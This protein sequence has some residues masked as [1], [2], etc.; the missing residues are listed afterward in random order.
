MKK[1][2]LV[3][4]LV[5]ITVSGVFAQQ[6]AGR[7]GV[8]VMGQYNLGFG[9]ASGSAGASLSLKLPQSPIFWGLRF[10][11]SGGFAF[12]LTGDVYFFSQNLVSGVDFGYRVAVGAY[13]RLAAGNNITDVGLGLRLPLGVYFMPIDFLELFFNVVPDLGVGLVFGNEFE[14]RFP[15]RGLC[16]E[17]GVRVWF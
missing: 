9:S 7:L 8:G 15:D 16:L 6:T 14:F 13:S 5:L 3:F 1:L 12:S 10:E 11:G 17:I 4:V 2:A